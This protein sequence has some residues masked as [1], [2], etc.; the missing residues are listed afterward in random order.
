MGNGVRRKLLISMFEFW[1]KKLKMLEEKNHFWRIAKSSEN[2]ENRT[3]ITKPREEMCLP[4]RWIGLRWAVGTGEDDRE[5]EEDKINWDKCTQ[6]I[7]HWTASHLQE[8]QVKR[9]ARESFEPHG[10]FSK[11]RLSARHEDWGS[12]DC[13]RERESSRIEKQEWRHTTTNSEKNIL[14]LS[15]FLW[16]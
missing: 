13:C 4:F 14:S 6:V 7:T 16:A 1:K 9:E 15:P 2:S 10:V 12:S 8:K 3:E 11:S 5:E